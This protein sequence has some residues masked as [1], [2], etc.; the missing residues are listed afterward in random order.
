MNPTP[1]RIFI[2]I[3][4]IYVSN[5]FSAIALIGDT[6]QARTAWLELQFSM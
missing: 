5:V 4:I 6:F 3:I 1:G 2:I